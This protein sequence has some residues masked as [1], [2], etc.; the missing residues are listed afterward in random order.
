MAYY[1]QPFDHMKA[2]NAKEANE[3]VDRLRRSRIA[4]PGKPGGQFERPFDHRK[5]E[6]ARQAQRQVE[7][8]QRAKVQRPAPK[9]APK[10]TP[11][12]ARPSLGARAGKVVGNALTRPVSSKAVATGAARLLG[13]GAI[14]A[15]GIPGAAAYGTYLVSDAYLKDTEAA[16]AMQRP[17]TDA[18]ARVSGVEDL[19]QR[20]L[21]DD[22]AVSKAA[23]AEY[24]AANPDAFKRPVDAAAAPAATPEAA[25][26]VTPSVATDPQ[27]GNAPAVAPV[28][29]VARPNYQVAPGQ[30]NPDI[31]TRPTLGA[32]GKPVID[33]ATGKA[34]PEF[35]D[36]YSVTGLSRPV[37]TQ[38]EDAAEQAR[39]DKARQQYIDNTTGSDGRRYFGGS[40]V[41]KLREAQM[42]E[43]KKGD[44]NGVVA[45]QLADEGLTPEQRA[46]RDA[47][48]VAY[49]QANVQANQS[50]AKA[51]MEA[52]K[53][54]YNMNRNAKTDARLNRTAAMKEADSILSSF[55]DTAPEAYQQLMA[56]AG[57]QF[58]PSTGE[59]M[60]SVVQRLLSSFELDGGIPLIDENGQLVQRQQQATEQ[61]EP[62]LWQ[63]SVDYFLG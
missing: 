10:P 23:V 54:S 16:K 49:H 61:A 48:P 55:K 12:P 5:A 7:N 13:K 51:Q 58:D 33:P 35:T 32:D 45:R 11:K 37:P 2:R 42:V 50:A 53:Q 43:A 59:S 3:A 21:S 9:A 36:A 20:M 62:G 56:M 30:S 38:G 17:V 40:A 1:D 28:A 4:T 63:K 6:Q 39:V 8:A 47:D 52:F 46:A 18:M 41:E 27:G 60:S 44:R 31:L 14:A 25:P 26:A 22:P 34:V 15:A 19:Q 29:P 57:E 24:K